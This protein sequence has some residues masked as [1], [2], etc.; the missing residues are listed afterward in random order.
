MGFFTQPEHTLY[1]NPL[2]AP[3][4]LASD[5]LGN[6]LTSGKSGSSLSKRVKSRKFT[7]VR[8]VGMATGTPQKPSSFAGLRIGGD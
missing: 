6:P 8:T 3:F 5:L 2:T 4:G 7:P 1:S